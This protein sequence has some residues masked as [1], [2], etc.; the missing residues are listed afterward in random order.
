MPK[1]LKK[2]SKEEGLKSGWWLEFFFCG[3]FF[4]KILKNIYLV[5]KFLIKNQK[6]SKLK[7]K[8]SL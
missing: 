6:K 2:R 8:S 7:K 4:N 3:F 1:I 5:L